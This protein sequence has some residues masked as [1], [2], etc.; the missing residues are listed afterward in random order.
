[1]AVQCL[2]FRAAPVLS[3]GGRGVGPGLGAGRGS[4]LRRSVIVV[5][6][7]DSLEGLGCARHR[8]ERAMV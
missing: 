5:D 8:T 1:M 6:L 7:V 4:P 2:R 3:A